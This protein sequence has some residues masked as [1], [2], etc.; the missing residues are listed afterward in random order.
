MTGRL[1]A[2]EREEH[3]V[4]RTR[5]ATYGGG[6][7]TTIG[8]VV[9]AAGRYEGTGSGAESGPFDATIEITPVLDGMGATIDYVAVASDGT[10]L[11]AEHTTLAFD[12]W[13]GQATLYVM[14]SELNGVG[15]LIEVSGSR[16]DNGQGID[17]FELQIEIALDD[18]LEYVWSWGAPGEPL[19]ERSRAVFE[20]R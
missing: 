20:L 12:S 2:S 7:E 4:D 16:F 14:C 15:Q 18:V 5:A 1:A 19:T 3:G 9:R 17:G 8:R 10:E 13:S 6:M 11:H